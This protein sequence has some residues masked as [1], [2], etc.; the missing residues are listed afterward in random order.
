[1]KAA[2]NGFDRW[3]TSGSSSLVGW[4]VARFVSGEQETRR[5]RPRGRGSARKQLSETLFGWRG[6][7]PRQRLQC[8]CAGGALKATLAVRHRSL[9]QEGG[10]IRIGL[11]E[12]L[13]LRSVSPSSSPVI[14]L[15]FR[16]H[17]R[18]KRSMIEGMRVLLKRGVVSNNALKPT[19]SAQ[20]DWGPRGLVQ[21]CAHVEVPTHGRGVFVARAK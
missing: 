16:I 17:E 12:A 19:R 13:G 4:R 3:P 14:G 10:A 2:A 20:T 11:S 8:L 9:R 21:C 1:M 5:N 15:G 7:Q 18:K 6:R